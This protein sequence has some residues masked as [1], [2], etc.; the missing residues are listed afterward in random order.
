MNYNQK[1]MHIGQGII[2]K[3]YLQP[4]WKDPYQVLL[5]SSRTER[6]K[7]SPKDFGIHIFHLERAPALDWPIERTADLKLTLKQCSNRGETAL[8]PR[9]EKDN[10]RSRW[11]FLDARPDPYDYLSCFQY[12]NY[13]R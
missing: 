10:I 5:T 6:L 11:L 12:N 2:L 1:I 8:T 4:R 3:A 7:E 9:Q 13:I